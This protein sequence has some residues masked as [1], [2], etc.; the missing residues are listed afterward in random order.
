MFYQFH[1]L[2]EV[3]SRDTWVAQLIERLTLDFS[4]GHDLMV[5]GIEPCALEHLRALSLVLALSLSLKNK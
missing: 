3:S 1:H 5:H 4:L 2:K